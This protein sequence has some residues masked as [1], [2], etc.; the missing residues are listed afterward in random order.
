MP[1]NIFLL[2]ILVDRTFLWTLPIINQQS[3]I[4]FELL[5]GIRIAVRDAEFKR[6]NEHSCNT[7]V[8]GLNM[9]DAAEPEPEAAEPEVAPKKAPATTNPAEVMSSA[10]PPPLEPEP[11][12]QPMHV[13]V[14]KD[15]AESVAHCIGE[16]SIPVAH[17]F[18][19]IA[20]TIVD[21]QLAMRDH[22]RNH[23]EW[24]LCCER[25]KNEHEE[26]AETVRNPEPDSEQPAEEVTPSTT[27]SANP[28]TLPD[29]PQPPNTPFPINV[30]YKALY[31]LVANGSNVGAISILLRLTCFGQTVALSPN[32]KPLVPLMVGDND[33]AASEC[34][35]DNSDVD[36]EI[37]KK[38]PEKVT[39]TMKLRAGTKNKRNRCERLP[40]PEL[41]YTLDA[42]K[43]F[44]F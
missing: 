34:N 43:L 15:D 25:I 29:E 19:R 4:E 18:E 1:L 21:Y 32:T 38:T 22:E 31:S 17:L 5:Q 7:C 27:E 28:I 40:K 11:Y 13:A 14:F 26:K 42:N 16:G 20:E 24:E 6:P 37:N 41:D 39:K 35:D 8:F 23:V 2:E 12:E 36:N 44:L 9:P 30:K 10:E 33:V 3:R